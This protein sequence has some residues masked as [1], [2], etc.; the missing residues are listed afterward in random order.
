MLVGIG[1]LSVV[2]ANVAAYFVEAGEEDND[3]DVRE[4]L[5]RMEQMLAELLAEKSTAKFA[6]P[7]GLRSGIESTT[8]VVDGSVGS[9]Q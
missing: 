5:E 9:A 6:S 1:L 3:A 8:T 7:A 4:R 2:T